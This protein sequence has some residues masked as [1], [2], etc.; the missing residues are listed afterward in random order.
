[1]ESQTVSDPPDSHASGPTKPEFTRFPRSQQL[2]LNA[3]RQVPPTPPPSDGT[4][5]A[6]IAASNT[7]SYCFLYAS[8]S[9]WY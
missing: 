4:P 3:A 8:A 2:G 7:F 9:S 6:R 1:M 5:S